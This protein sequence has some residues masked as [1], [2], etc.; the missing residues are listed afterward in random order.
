MFNIVKGNYVTSYYV[1]SFCWPSQHTFD[2]TK[3][4]NYIIISLQLHTY[5]FSPKKKKNSIHTS[6][7]LRS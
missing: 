3:I 7:V 4:N 2:K 6:Q 1:H 5:L